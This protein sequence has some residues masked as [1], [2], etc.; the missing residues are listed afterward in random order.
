MYIWKF[1]LNFKYFDSVWYSRGKENS[2]Y[3]GGK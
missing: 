2:R 1:L 3:G